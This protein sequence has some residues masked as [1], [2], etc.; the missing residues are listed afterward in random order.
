MDESDRSMPPGKID[1]IILSGLHLCNYFSVKFHEIPMIKDPQ[2]G[3]CPYC[4]MPKNYAIAKNLE[5]H[6]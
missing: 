3:I 5:P 6:G 2:G 4:Q 1:T